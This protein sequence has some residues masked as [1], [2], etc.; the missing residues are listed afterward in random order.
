[1]KMNMKEYENENMK[2]F[3]FLENKKYV[4]IWTKSGG[5]ITVRMVIILSITYP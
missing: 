5:N 1:M 2:T 3:L 4:L